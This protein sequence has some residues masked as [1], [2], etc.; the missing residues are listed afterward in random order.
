MNLT[1]QIIGS[2]LP[3]L[4]SYFL[5]YS[6]LYKKQRYKPPAELADVNLS[7][8][9]III[10]I[11]DDFIIYVKKTRDCNDISINSLLPSIRAFLYFATGIEIDD[12]IRFLFEY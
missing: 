12:P 8:L 4:A 5:V 6:L 11:I 2:I 10:D 1:R 7:I 3:D 9:I